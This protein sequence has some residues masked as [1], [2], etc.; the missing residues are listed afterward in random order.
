MVKNSLV[1]RAYA[2]KMTT[3]GAPFLSYSVHSTKSSSETSAQAP[4][5]AS[6]IDSQRYEQK[7]SP[8]AKWQSRASGI[9]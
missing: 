3:R 1:Y 9:Y 6:P 8:Y 4:L 5:S 2:G 7:R